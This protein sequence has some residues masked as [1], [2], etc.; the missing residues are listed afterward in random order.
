MKQYPHLATL[1]KNDAAKE[2]LI[3]AAICVWEEIPEEVLNK[4]IDSIIRRLEAVIKAGG[5]YTKY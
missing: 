4:L 2:E 3:R 5:W 1:P